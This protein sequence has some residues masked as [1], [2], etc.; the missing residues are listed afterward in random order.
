M[1][2]RGRYG[3]EEVLEEE[4]LVNMIKIYC[5]H[6]CMHEILKEQIIWI[7][8]IHIQIMNIHTHIHIHT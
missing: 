7:T 5:I 8:Y 2:F 1:K 6:A 3:T 4:L